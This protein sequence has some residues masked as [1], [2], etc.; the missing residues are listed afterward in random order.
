MAGFASAEFG[1]SFG[2][3]IERL[4]ERGS[5]ARS[6]P[7][8]SKATLAQVGINLEKSPNRWATPP[9]SPKARAPQTSAPPR[10]RIDDA[11]EAKNTISNVGLLL[12]AAGTK[13]VTAIGGELAG[14]SVHT[15]GSARNR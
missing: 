5:P 1:K 10:D 15:P 9:A 13:G 12:R 8:N 11:A 7:A 2:E 6:N 3:G 14:F 4:Y